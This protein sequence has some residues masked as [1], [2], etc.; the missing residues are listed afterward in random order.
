MDTSASPDLT[1]RVAELES[2][3]ADL[4]RDRPNAP[5]IFDLNDVSGQPSRAGMVME[6]DR[7]SGEWRPGHVYEP[8]DVKWTASNIAP[9]GRW[10]IA[11][12]AAVSRA[13]YD[14]L[15]E[16][17]GTD[18]G[19]GDGSTTF[20]LPDLQGT[21]ALAAG[22]P[23]AVGDTG[24]DRT[25]VLTITEMP[26]HVHAQNVTAA[27]GGS[28][29]RTDYDADAASDPF[30]Q[31]INTEATGGGAAHNNMPPYVALWAYIR[32]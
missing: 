27:F 6:Y 23:E 14:Q 30:P 31:G 28:G 8:G 10:L 29:V 24:G 26:S 18:Y 32:Y 4:Q 13:D 5:G 21:F 2:R 12:G 20:N 17:I 7:V 15:F 16:M 9:A 22:N 25:H 1:A 3:M 19:V 11:D